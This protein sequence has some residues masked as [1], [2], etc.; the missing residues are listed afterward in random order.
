[1]A[2][3]YIV[4]FIYEYICI[5]QKKCFIMKCLISFCFFITFCNV[6]AQNQLMIHH[7]GN[8]LYGFE[9]IDTPLTQIAGAPEPFYSY[10]W[11]FG[12]G[13]YSTAQNPK[14][15]YS[16][17]GLFNVLVA[18]TNNY[19]DGP[20]R[21][22]KSNKI[23]INEP[24]IASNIDEMKYLPKNESYRLDKNQNPKANEEIIF[25]Q[26]YKNAS[27][28]IQKGTLIFF[29]NQKEFDNEHFVLSSYR[30][31]FNEKEIEANKNSLIEKINQINI[32]ENYS[33]QVADEQFYMTMLAS[34]NESRLQYE[35]LAKDENEI[36]YFNSIK[37]LQKEI[38]Q[39]FEDYSHAIAFNFDQLA[40]G[41]ERNLFMTFKTTQTM[42]EDTNIS[43]SVQAFFIP[44]NIDYATQ[45]KHIMPI[46]TAHDP[47]KLIV[48]KSKTY[49]A[50]TKQKALTYEIKFQNVG[51]GPAEDVKLRFYNNADINIKKIEILAF[52]PF[53]DFCKEN[54]KGSYIDTLITK[55][56]VEFFFHNIYLPGTRQ[57]DIQNRDASKGYIKF[58]LQTEKKI[59]Q[60]NLT[61]RTEIYFDKE[62]PI[63]TNNSKTR[64]LKRLYF[65]VELGTN[66]LPL[67]YP[68]LDLFLRGTMT[69]RLTN[70][71]FYRLELG[72]TYK[73]ITKEENIAID[74]IF[75]NQSGYFEVLDSNQNI[76]NTINY[77]FDYISNITKTTSII[78]KQGVQLSFV[79]LS[80]RREINAFIN[81]GLGI[82]TTLNL[83]RFTKIDYYFEREN[84]QFES[85]SLD[86]VYT[87]QN[88]QGQQI[89]YYKVNRQ[90][91]H[92]QVN[93]T[94]TESFKTYQFDMISGLFLDINIGKIHSLPYF[95]IRANVDYHFTDKKINPALQFYLGANF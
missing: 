37:H 70:N 83:V 43:I 1:M 5:T 50:F 19:D 89:Y 21:P 38:V 10:W 75:T 7:N 39:S 67:A 91:T 46:V 27:T 24:L 64:M 4:L 85:I 17:N 56:Y 71:W 51:K 86:S 78:K 33:S 93:S 36:A 11:E 77:E 58:T 28:S 48:D 60:N 12:D 41:E 9:S 94:K 88:G 62:Q 76:V 6:F 31:H 82:N 54:C 25:V 63:V 2:A 35:I 72:S 66:Y 44:E 23:K 40:P 95:G 8:A 73:P 53:C 69:L 59:K 61:C 80:F 57:S 55:D 65:G 52:E 13:H 22:T 34:S 74:T 79:P 45:V 87:G 84:T 15:Q 29:Y 81:I 90:F 3:F 68:R 26:T 42:L 47:N 14:H 18:T 49:R 92:N 32:T 30:N 20:R 16:K